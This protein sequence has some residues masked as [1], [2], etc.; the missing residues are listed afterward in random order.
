VLGVQD[1]V[2][3]LTVG[4]DADVIVMDGPPLSMKSWVVRAYVNGELVHERK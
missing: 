1:R 2:G 3:S 4:K